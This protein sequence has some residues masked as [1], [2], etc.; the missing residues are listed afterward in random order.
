MIDSNL[1]LAI[2]AAVRD[3]LEALATVNEHI[4]REAARQG[5]ASALQALLDNAEECPE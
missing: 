3:H 5:V 1:R 2:A 4:V